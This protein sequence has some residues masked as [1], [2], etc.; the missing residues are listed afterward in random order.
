MMNDAIHSLRPEFDPCTEQLRQLHHIKPRLRWRSDC[1]P[2]AWTQDLRHALRLRLGL[3]PEN[4]PLEPVFGPVQMDNNHSTQAFRITVEPGVQAP[5]WIVRP[6]AVSNPPVVICLQG[7]SSGAHLSIGREL[8]PQD[9]QSIAGGRDF[10]RQV[11]ARGWAAIALEQRA[12]GL[13]EDRRPDAHR[14][15]GLPHFSDHHRCEH[16]AMAELLLGR[17]LAGSRVHDVQRVCDFIAE[18]DNVDHSRIAVMGHSGGGTIS[19]YSAALEPRIAACM[20]SCSFS[21]YAESIGSIDH[22]ADNYLFGALTDFDM[23]DLA[24][25]IAPRPLIVVAG[26]SDPIFP[27]HAVRSGFAH[28]QDIFTHLGAREQCALVVGEEGHRFYPNEAWPIFERLTG[29]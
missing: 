19:F 8:H 3:C 29:W 28:A 21:P 10:A 2:A 17:T 9:A 18:L 11:A 22:C 12:F 6:L 5:G 25:L 13:R 23:T 15:Q 7:H 1:D 24:G 27:I 20:P 16:L 4:S 14:H 26:K